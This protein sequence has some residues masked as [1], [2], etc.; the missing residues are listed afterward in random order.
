MKAAV[1]VDYR[2]EEA[3][4]AVRSMHG[5]HRIPTLLRRVDGLCRAAP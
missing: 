1:D 2:E 3:I 5:D 4:R